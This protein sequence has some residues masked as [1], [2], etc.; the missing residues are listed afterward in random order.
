MILLLNGP[1]GVGKTA[2]A[3]ALAPRFGDAVLL[4]APA[5]AAFPPE[6]WLDAP[7]RRQAEAALLALVDHHL[8]AGRRRFLITGVYPDPGELG[9]LLARLAERSAPAL[10]FRLTCGFEDLKRRLLASVQAGDEFGLTL[11]R[12]RALLDLLNAQGGESG[13]GRVV[14]TT[15]SA[16]GTVADRI[17][18]ISQAD[19]GA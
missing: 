8:A 18:A 17:W 4:D 11:R 6:D 10:A 2:V 13:L 1:P 7:Y 3:R 14:L 12:G 5:L 9:A 16:L 15:D 19:L